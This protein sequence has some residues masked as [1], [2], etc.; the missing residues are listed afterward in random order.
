AC[1]G[2][3]PLIDRAGTTILALPY[4][5]GEGRM[6]D[7]RDW[8]RKCDL[9]SLAGVLAAND[10]DL[11]ILPS[12]TDTDF[13]KLGISLGQRRK[14]LR[15]IAALPGTS[16]AVADAQPQAAAATAGPAAE[17]E[18]RQL[19]VMFCDLVGSTAL[20]AQVDPEDLATSPVSLIHICSAPSSSSS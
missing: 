20:S 7:L 14:L 18:R 1:V 19:T 13:E 15:A 12:L 6:A 9:E 17:A 5:L 4:L 16:G 2:H 11:D 8:L 3:L 10:V